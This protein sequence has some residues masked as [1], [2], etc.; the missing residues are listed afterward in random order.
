MNKDKIKNHINTQLKKHIVRYFI[1]ASFVVGI[2]LATFA[3][4][5]SK[6]GISYLIA[7]PLSNIVAIFLNWYLS[8]TIV[9]KG[10]SVHKQHIEF[11]LIIIVSVAGVGIQ[12]LVTFICVESLQLAPI[13]GKCLAIIVVFFWSYWTRKKYIFKGAGQSAL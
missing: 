13:I 12:E 2:E 9:F 4:L 3:F 6:L 5:N 8:R 1:M 7:T 10:G 11:I